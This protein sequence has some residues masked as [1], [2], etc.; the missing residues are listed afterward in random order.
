MISLRYLSIIFALACPL[1]LLAQ[2]TTTRSTTE[3]PEEKVPEPQLT[4]MPVLVKSVEPEYPK[5]AL[6]DKVETELVLTINIDEFGD[7]EEIGLL[8]PCAYP[9]Y[10]FEEAAFTALSLFKFEPAEFDNVP[11]PVSITY[12]FRFTLPPPPPDPILKFEG[13]LVE[14]GTNKILSGMV[15]SVF[16]ANEDDPEGFEATTDK[17][18]V[19]R[20]Y[21]L[22]S[23]K[24]NVFASP[25][26]YYPLRTQEEIR[27]DERLEAKYYMERKSYNPFD[28]MIRAPREKKEVNRATITRE[29]I[30]KIPGGLGD[31]IAVLQNLPSVARAPRSGG[32]LIVRGSAPED[33]RTFIDGIEVPL[34]YHFGGL[35]SAIPVGML[36]TLDFYTGNFG[37][38]YGRATGGMLD[39]RLKKLEPEQLSGYVDVSLL[40]SGVYIETPLGEDGAIAIAGRRSYVDFILNAAIPE[41]APVNLI[42]APRYYDFQL[43]G[44][45]QPSPEHHFSAFGLFSDDTFKLLFENPAEF[46][47]QLR[48]GSLETSSTFY[49]I[50]LDHTWIPSQNIENSFQ[51]S[52]G[53]NWLQFF[54]GEQFKFDLNFYQSQ[55][56]DTFRWKQS[57]NF[58]LKTGF[59]YIF[60]KSD[61]DI[62]LPSPPKEGDPLAQVSGA[63]N[64]DGTVS[65]QR[66]DEIYHS[67]GVFLDAELKL[68]NKLLLI[69]GM[70]V[71]Y[72]SRVEQFTYG[73]RLTTRY[74]ATP[75]LNIKAG[76]GIYHQEPLFD[77]TDALYGNPNLN[78]ERAFHYSLGGEYKFLPYLSLDTTFFY[79]D[80]DK[81]ISRTDNLVGEGA[82]TRAKVY[83]LKGQGRVYGAEFLLRHKFANNFFGWLAY[84][85]SRSERIDSA[86]TE[87]RLFDYDQTH[88]LA[89]LG[90]YR[91]PRNWEVGLRIQYVT[92]APYTPV[93]G[94]IYHAD[95]DRYE[96]IAGTQASS[97]LRNYRQFDLRVDKRWIY[98]TWIF[99]L[100]LDIQNLTNE[101]NVEAYD[102]NYDFSK[103]EASQGLPILTILGLKVEF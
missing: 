9:G 101:S 35:R 16:P 90:T 77:E 3:A 95:R 2:D 80:L 79:K 26:G 51:S 39:V 31:P 41:S 66:N 40:D 18:G 43:L 92:G 65:A 91:L 70:R 60:L 74:E 62:S 17:Q 24:W 93:A 84:T 61:I 8:Q 36:D 81:V 64:V 1:Q 5:R 29:E 103:K 27:K 63:S 100:Y 10:G 25:D 46:S 4:K 50:I 52:A 85:L 96:P 68:F 30:E 56:R 33:T 7:V 12:K 44:N 11:S 45:Y 99:N 21:D 72:F 37:T 15:I 97:R 78:C 82:E 47:T 49:R 58:T 20:F 83:D 14:R 73:P 53:R 76:A 67:P 48:S 34:I 13:T 71:D 42:A 102:Y 87:Y 28:V 23:G 55:T 57:D 59:D 69:P 19:F 6:A 88:I 38:A 89:L 98:E 94:S 86:S 75:L 22:P 54:L 32:I